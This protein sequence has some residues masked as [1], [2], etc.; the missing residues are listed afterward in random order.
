MEGLSAGGQ[1]QVTG[2]RTKEDEEEEE[3]GN[4]SED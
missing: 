4:F 1:D 2:W 3:E